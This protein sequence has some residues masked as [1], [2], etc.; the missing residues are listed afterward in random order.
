MPSRRVS[1]QAK[2]LGLA[3]LLLSFTAVV[4]VVGISSVTSVDSIAEELFDDSTQP[5]EQLGVAHATANESRALLNNH[6]LNNH[7]EGVPASDQRELERSIAENDTV[8]EENLAKVEPSLKTE[9]DNAAFNRIQT[10]LA[11][12][13]ELR[14]RVLAI[15][16][17][18]EGADAAET[19]TLTK[20]AVALNT[21]EAVP[22]FKEAAKAFDELF[23]SKVE[24]AEQ[25]NAEI[26]STSAS[27]RTLSLVLLAL[28]LVLGV[29]TS[30]LVARGIRRGVT[31]VRDTLNHLQNTC[32]A[33]LQGGLRALAAGDLTVEVVPT[34]P[35]IEKPSNDE[36]GDVAR[37]VNE[38]REATVASLSEYN[39][40]RESLGA[41]VS[42]IHGTAGTVSAASQQMASTSDEAGR[43][44]S[45][46]AHAV[47][48]VAQGAE[49]QV[50]TVESAKQMTEDIVTATAGSAE[51][52]EQ[53]AEAAE[54]ARSAADQGAEAVTKATE[55]M[56]AVRDSSGEATGAIRALG[57]KS[58]QIGGIVA[59]I[60]GIAEQTNLL[61]LN[62][63]IEAARAGEQGRGFAVVAEEV[64]KLA[65]ESQTAAATIAG[66]IGEIQTE[67][68]RAVDVVE[69]GARATE[70]GVTTVE[71]VHESFTVIGSSIEAV[72]GR[73]AEIAA[74]IGQI[75]GFSTQM[76]ND[77]AEV[78]AVA[79]QSSA[80][81]EQVSASTQQTSASTQEIA[82]SAQA[83]AR[84]AEELE[85]LVGRFTLAR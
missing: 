82:G 54:H 70:D 49:R 2:L 18:M 11:R 13:R 20:D 5:L 58:E 46:I 60:T 85:Q 78:A 38:I 80:S 30:Y 45:E 67:T 50:R 15:S 29:L 37:T 35:P 14:E 62:A 57:A 52:A 47:G 24:L 27:R 74:A 55:A 73:V 56:K 1:L 21:G 53:T 79:E 44:V 31:R 16:R 34:T 8:I 66:L 71:R 19:D 23:A 81:A 63:A 4:A 77:M 68:N 40:T 3:A 33:G 64:R 75:A 9:T 17:S 59:T 26:A 69:T 32:I 48:D 39:A 83:L 76:Q 42:Q 28:A 7:V 65:E 41:L 51:N 25:E 43:A 10:S 12:W 36:I 72:H 22:A 6:L 84:S 61:A